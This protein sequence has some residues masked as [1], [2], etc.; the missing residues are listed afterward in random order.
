MVY[1]LFSVLRPIGL[2]FSVLT[3]VCCLLTIDVLSSFRRYYHKCNGDNRY[4][5][6]HHNV[7]GQCFAE[8]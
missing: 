5:N 8:E 7:C 6:A 3:V 1:S 2:S 4:Y